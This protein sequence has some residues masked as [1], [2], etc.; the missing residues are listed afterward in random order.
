MATNVKSKMVS[1]SLLRLAPFASLFALAACSGVLGIETLNEGPRP[2]SG[3][4]AGTANSSGGDGISA[5]GDAISASGNGGKSN[6]NGGNSALAG[7]GGTSAGGEAGAIETGGTGGSTTGGTAGTGGATGGTVTGHVIDFREHA[8]SGVPVEIGGKQTVTDAQGAFSIA[9]VAATYDASLVVEVGGDPTEQHAYVF[10]GLTRRDP[11]LQVFIAQTQQTDSVDVAV[12]GATLTGTREL[13]VSLSSANGENEFSDITPGT[14]AGDAYWR[15]GTTDQETAYGL[16][17]Q[18]DKNGLPASYVAYD[19]EPVALDSSDSKDA[20]V[21]LNMTASTI[22]T[23]NITGTVTPAGTDTRANYAFLQFP[24]NGTITL[25]NDAGPNAF[26]YLMPSVKGANILFA[27]TEGDAGTGQ[28]TLAHKDALQPG[29]ASFGL[30]LPI[31]V[32]RVA[33]APAASVD[34]VDGTVTFSFVPGAGNTG[35]FVIQ[36]LNEQSFP[37]SSGAYED[38]RL[39]IITAQTSFK[40]PEVVNDT[41][42][43]GPG[44][45]YYWRVMTHGVFANVDAL[46]GSTGFMDPFSGSPYAYEEIYPVGPRRGDG[47]FT[48]SASQEITIAK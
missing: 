27:A 47:A 42:A 32:S 35:P 13:S 34:K 48:I 24:T 26:T 6:G 14:D 41:F 31:P 18:A 37:D 23:G 4:S 39:Y 38:D 28:F 40:L 1:R 15:G 46:A 43:L 12:T 36:F 7:T 17:W 2:G 20:S 16:I 21:T 10:Q 30:S 8:V 19:T 22:A 44:N 3:G 25:V 33:V 9:G 11:T 29:A 45:K 5:G